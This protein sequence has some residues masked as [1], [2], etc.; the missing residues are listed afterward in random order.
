VPGGAQDLISV[1]VATLDR[2]DSLASTLDALRAQTYPAVE[3][4]VVVGPCSDHTVAVLRAFPETTV[5]AN[6]ERNLSRSRNL[7][8]AAARG[9]VVAFV[10]DDAVPAADWVEGLVDGLEVRDPGGRPVAGVGGLVLGPDGRTPEWWYCAVDM[11]G[12]GHLSVEA[13]THLETSDADDPAAARVPFLAGTNAAYRRDALAEVGGFDERLPYYLDDAQ[14][15]VALWERGWTVAAVHGAT[16]HH[17][18]LA[19]VVRARDDGAT[20]DWGPV[21]TSRATFA[22]QHA[23]PLVGAARALQEL[24]RFV[25]GAR[26]ELGGDPV[27]EARLERDARAAREIV[28]GP[29]RRRRPAPRPT[30]SLVV[31]VHERGGLAAAVVEELRDLADEVVVACDVRMRDG[32]LGRLDA[33]ADRLLTYEYTEPNRFRPW[34]REQA[35]GEWLLLLDGDEMPSADLVAQLPTLIADRDCAGFRFPC[36]WIH[37]DG[38]TR[39]AGPPWE[40]DL[41]VRLVRNSANLHF[42]GVKHTGVDLPHPSKVVLAPLLHL[43]LVVNDLATRRAKVQ[44][45]DGERFGQLT[46]DGH[47]VNPAFYLPED[48]DPPRAPLGDRDV[49]RIA[50]VVARAHETAPLDG[51]PP[52]HDAAEL[53]RWWTGGSMPD[54]DHRAR[55]DVVA[56]PAGLVAGAPAQVLARVTNTGGSLWPA[57]AEGR[58]RPV[59]LSYRWR[60]PDGSIAVADGVRTPLSAR[61]APGQELIT[62]VD[63]A[64]PPAPGPYDLVLDLVHEGVRWF[65]VDEVVRCEVAPDPTEALLAAPGGAATP[66]AA[67]AARRV[68]AQHEGLVHALARRIGTPA[69]RDVEGLGATGWA[70]DPATTRSLLDHLLHRSARCVLHLGGGANALVLAQGVRAAGGRVVTLDHDERRAIRVRRTAADLGLDDVLEVHHAPIAQVVADHLAVTGIDASVLTDLDRVDA[71]VLDVPVHPG[72]P[73][74]VGVMAAVAPLLERPTR[75]VADDAF[76]DA[77]LETARL[78][79]RAGP[80]TIDGILV[81][82][83]P[84]AVGVTGRARRP[85]PRRLSLPFNSGDEVGVGPLHI[86]PHRRLAGVTGV[87]IV[88]DSHLL[89]SSLLGRRIMLVHVDRSTG[90]RQV[91][92]QLT[93]TAGGRPTHTDLLDHDGSSRVL[94]SNCEANS[95][96]LYEL[97]DGEL[98]WERELAIE[99]PAM[100]FCHGVQFS[101]WD[102]EV[103]VVASTAGSAVLVVSLRDGTVLRTIDCGGLHAKDA[104]F[105]A[106][107][108]IAV[109]AA[110]GQPT[111]GQGA[112]YGSAIRLVALGAGGAAEI[113]DEVLLDASHVDSCRHVGGE[114]Y[115]T[116]QSRGEVAVFRIERARRVEHRA[117]IDGF[118]HPHAVDVRPDLGLLAVA[119]YGTDA[120]E[121]VDL[122]DPPA[123]PPARRRILPFA[124]RQPT[125]SSHSEPA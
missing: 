9:A 72:A 5:V 61:V 93:T 118:R 117:T 55:I 92:S 66:A 8:I 69:G 77:M 111:H 7:G 64:A 19:G 40:D 49:A 86:G 89:V 74:R 98:R 25:A 88:D 70:A 13:P 60:R 84:L 116:K 43:D 52:H 122:D 87:R 120:V 45:Y 28:A 113:L 91:R 37:P 65:G 2:A 106:A 41:V 68:L 100:S 14:L 46:R 96:S 81:T 42:P 44:R 57:G 21:L 29:R 125:S 123:P 27:A 6:P 53:E 62:P 18:K 97:Q 58:Q 30:L 82:R 35:S 75:L 102:P 112:T 36:H 101:P 4:I 59:L 31:G 105:V 23:V 1:V 67:L 47:P 90:A 12:G 95:I 78:W 99:H 107:D 16:V 48:V 121:L 114:L 15:A 26:A 22:R 71:V 17:R 80:V 3:V 73:A 79:T 110:A 54:A 34:L 20:T 83:S 119:D 109:V 103:A 56:A 76:S 38:R 85:G 115:V 51:R 104:A 24:E 50:G 124:R 63:L 94:V 108:T 33:V 10:D 39:L 32:D 11:Y